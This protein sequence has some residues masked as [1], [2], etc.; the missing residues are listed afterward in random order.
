MAQSSGPLFWR[1]PR[2]P[3]VELRVVREGRKV[4]Y[5][6][7]SHLQWSLGAI[8]EG[9]STFVYQDKEVLV[10][11]GTLV[12]MN[13]HWVHACNPVDNQ[14]WGYLMLYID[15][16][17]LTQ[18]RFDAG[19]LGSCHWQDITT[20]VIREPQWFDGYCQLAD[21]LLDDSRVL[22]DK[23][24]AVVE[25]LSALFFE[26]ADSQ[27]PRLAAVPQKLQKLADYIR[28]HAADDVSLDSLC[29]QSGYSPGHLVRAFKQYFGLTPHAYLLNC[30]VQL[31][32]H[33]LKQ[34]Q[35]IAQTALEL[36]FADQAHFQRTFKRLVAATPK[37]Y[38]QSLPEQQIQRTQC[39]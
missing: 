23:Q 18:L 7:H 1:D 5:A 29:E 24:V 31:G 21:C 20:S 26:L 10:T 28:M 13:P 16:N 2:M 11:A 22:L 3:Y 8:T 33:A 38:R 39:K 15:A 36:G 6:P 30:R 4:C 9:C 17:W 34:G 25:Y 19:L 35:P 12:M 32:Q 27:A 37:Q 14:P